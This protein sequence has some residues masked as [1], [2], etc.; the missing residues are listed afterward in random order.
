MCLVLSEII[1]SFMRYASAVNQSV[2][3]SIA[4]ARG[5]SSIFDKGR[6][7]IRYYPTNGVIDV[8]H[9]L[10]SVRVGGW[11]ESLTGFYDECFDDIQSEKCEKIVSDSDKKSD[12]MARCARRVRSVCRD[13]LLSNNWEYWVTLT[14]SDEKCD[15]RDLRAVLNRLL[16]LVKSRNLKWPQRP[17]LKYLL[18]PEQHKDGAYHLHGFI[19]GVDG[20][21]LFVNEHGHLDFNLFSQNLGFVNIVPVRVLPQIERYALLTYTLKYAQKSVE[22]CHGNVRRGYFRSD[23]LKRSEVVVLPP[24]DFR[25][26]LAD[27][28]GTVASYENKYVQKHTYTVEDFETILSVADF[29][30]KTS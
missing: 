21:E 13:L 1:D 23:G 6:L 24:S 7:S 18:L 3:R 28:H 22:A 16:N 11:E 5:V 15:R 2:G 4:P 25:T 8:V 29:S 12:N 26:A 20:D 17:P 10:K 14:V 19:M 30:E 9:H 27:V